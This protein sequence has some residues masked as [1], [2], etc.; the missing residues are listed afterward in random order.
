MNR[1]TVK[2]VSIFIV[3]FLLFSVTVPT[4]DPADIEDCSTSISCLDLDDDFSSANSWAV[5]TTTVFIPWD[6]RQPL[7]LSYTPKTVVFHGI[8][9][10]LN[11]ISRSP[12]AVLA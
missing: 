2:H 7:I 11:H 6:H 9:P 4:F 12:P 8:I 10:F 3:V 5:E 1:F